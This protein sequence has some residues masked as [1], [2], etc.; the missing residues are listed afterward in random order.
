MS[1]GAELGHFANSIKKSEIQWGKFERPLW[2]R[3]WAYLRLQQEW[4]A[5]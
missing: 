5:G 3:R 2:V 1:L 4:T